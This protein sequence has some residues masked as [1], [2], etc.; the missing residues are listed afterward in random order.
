MQIGCVGV[1][2]VGA[3]LAEIVRAKGE[4]PSF[5]PEQR[6]VDT[7]HV[8]ARPIELVDVQRVVR[9]EI[10]RLFSV[11]E[12]DPVTQLSP[13]GEEEVRVLG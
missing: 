3:V 4:I 11:R 7:L 13:L 12:G 2:I 1:E 8:V 5:E 9:R 6:L 10:D